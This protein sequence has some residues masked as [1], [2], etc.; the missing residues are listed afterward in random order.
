MKSTSSLPLK[1]NFIKKSIV[2]AMPRVMRMCHFGPIIDHLPKHK[3]IAE[4]D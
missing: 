2:E 1:Y 4:N 3:L